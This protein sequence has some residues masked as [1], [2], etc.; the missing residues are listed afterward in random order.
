MSAGGPGGAAHPPGAGP[1]GTPAGMQPTVTGPPRR[2]GG[3]PARAPRR[4][5]GWL[6]FLGAALCVPLAHRAAVAAPDEAPPPAGW[7]RAVDPGGRWALDLPAGF[8]AVPGAGGIEARDPAGARIWLQATPLVAGQDPH[9]R[10][11]AAERLLTQGLGAG[12]VSARGEGRLGTLDAQRLD[13][14]GL[15]DGKAGRLRVL[16][17]ETPREELTLALWVPGADPDAYDA[18]FEQVARSVRSAAGVPPLAGARVAGSGW[19]VHLPAGAVVTSQRPEGFT[20][21]DGALQ[22]HFLRAPR[23]AA[24]TDALAADFLAQARRGSPGLTLRRRATALVAGAEALL[25][26]LEDGP[27][28]GAGGE[29]SEAR[30]WLQVRADHEVVLVAEYPAAERSLRVPQLDRLLASVVLD[31]EGGQA[32]PPAEPPPAGADP[33]APPP[34]AE[35]LETRLGPRG[36]FLLPVPRRW[37][38]REEARDL[39]AVSPDGRAALRAHSDAGSNRRPEAIRDQL[40]S[41]L[42]VAAGGLEVLREASLPV[43]GAFDARIVQ[44]RHRVGEET[45]VRT[46]VVTFTKARRHWLWLSVREDA[47]ADLEGTFAAV[48]DGYRP[49]D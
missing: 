36:H 17:A 20:A 43:P 21:T 5:A 48:L 28:E 29:R 13:L 3:R 16:R 27:P 39:L 23:A 18:A 9:A 12:R 37:T 11:V 2:A 49:R 15:L 32:P 38:V 47:R 44:V 14:V 46:L 40:L 34:P 22:I 10:A 7:T 26:V 35:P 30:A 6:L 33:A 31:G 24:S 41:S 1:R 25:L 45:W 8:A 19:E 4:R 42:A